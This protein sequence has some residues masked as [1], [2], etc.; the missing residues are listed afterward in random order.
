MKKPFYSEGCR[1]SIIKIYKDHE[2]GHAKL[3]RCQ[4]WGKTPF[5]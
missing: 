4:K 3:R 1:G 2:W 5:S